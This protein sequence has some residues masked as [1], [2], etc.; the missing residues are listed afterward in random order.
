MLLCAC[1]LI[2]KFPYRYQWYCHV[3]Y[4]CLDSHKFLLPHF[5]SAYLFINTSLW[6]GANEEFLSNKT[7]AV[8]V[9]CLA[10]E[11]ASRKYK[12]THEYTNITTVRKFRGTSTFSAAPWITFYLALCSPSYIVLNHLIYD[13]IKEKVQHVSYDLLDSYMETRGNSLLVIIQ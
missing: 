6:F 8:F 4:H 13:K 7:S 10:C 12:I 5:L 9:W 3:Q 1:P 11:V 2:T